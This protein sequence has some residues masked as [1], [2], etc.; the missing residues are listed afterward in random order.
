M[1]IDFLPNSVDV[2]NFIGQQILVID[3]FHDFGYVDVAAG[4]EYLDALSDLCFLLRICVVEL[5][6]KLFSFFQRSK[7]SLSSRISLCLDHG[8]A[9]LRNDHFPLKISPLNNLFIVF[10]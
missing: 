1:V 10:R 3:P 6:H 5:I 4:Q 2:T 8:F 7:M 9:F